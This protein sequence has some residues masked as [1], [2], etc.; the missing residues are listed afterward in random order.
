MNAVVLEKDKKELQAKLL[1]SDKDRLLA[2][3]READLT[4]KV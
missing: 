2:T 4:K 1:R 3:Q